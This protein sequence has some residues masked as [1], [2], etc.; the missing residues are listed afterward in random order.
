[1]S[2]HEYSLLLVTQIPVLLNNDAAFTLDLWC[3]DISVN[4]KY[5]AK[6][7]IICPKTRVIK[8]GIMKIPSHIEVNIIDTF[9]PIKTIHSIMKRYDVIQFAGGRPIWYCLRDLFILFS[10]KRMGKMTL[11][12]ISSN[13]VKLTLLNSL[14]KSFIK[15]LKAKFIATSINLTQRFFSKHSDA[16]LLVG[17]TL[18]KALGIHHKNI[19]VE[20]A[21]WIEESDIVSDQVIQK[22]L[23]ARPNYTVPKL[24]IC[25]RLKTMKGVHIAIHALAGLRDQFKL[26]PML[27]I[28]GEGPELTNLKNLVATLD[29]SQQVEFLGCV[30]Y[31]ADFFDAIKKYDLILLTNLSDEQPRLIFDALAQGLIP[32]CPNTITYK[33]VGLD[34]KVLYTQGDSDDLARVIN[35]YTDTSLFTSMMTL[36]RQLLRQGTIDSMHVNRSEWIKGLL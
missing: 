31:G 34:D 23:S 15:K 17:S 3:K 8:G 24:C 21:S 13:R 30:A 25:T 22:K 12:S 10:A 20:L 2:K 19:H 26:M 16:V 4:A 6:I 35:A 27:S 36:S 32:I 28:Y 9:L 33:N 7:G 5:V 1:M 14:N 18:K 11:Y 29:L